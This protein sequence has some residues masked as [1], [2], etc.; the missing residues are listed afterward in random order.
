MTSSKMPFAPGKKL[1]ANSPLTNEDNYS[2]RLIQGKKLLKE[3]SKIAWEIGRIFAPIKFREGN[4][5]CFY[6]TATKY[7]TWQDYVNNELGPD[8]P[9]YIDNP[10]YIDRCINS[11]KIR[12]ILRNHHVPELPQ[13]IKNIESLATVECACNN[14]GDWPPEKV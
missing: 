7:T 4:G 1:L 9:Q 8:Y 14:K 11:W 5:E 13:S 3:G 6:K 12:Q 2:S 10:Q